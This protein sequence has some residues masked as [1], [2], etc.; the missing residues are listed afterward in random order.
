MLAL[1]AKATVTVLPDPSNCRLA[2]PP[3][4]VSLLLLPA[5]S[6]LPFPQS[7][8]AVL[9]E[10][11]N[12]APAP[13]DDAPLPSVLVWAETLPGSVALKIARAIKTN[14]SRSTIA[15]VQFHR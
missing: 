9:P 8:V 12:C 3:V 7:S 11:A 6:A 15:I 5:I 1:F 13:S 14:Q 10:A 2:Q 4:K